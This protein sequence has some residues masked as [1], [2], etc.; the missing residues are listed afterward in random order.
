MSRP[1]P[2]ALGLTVTPLTPE[3]DITIDAPGDT[4]VRHARE[5]PGLMPRY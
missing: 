1:A 4:V 5:P 2:G 3:G